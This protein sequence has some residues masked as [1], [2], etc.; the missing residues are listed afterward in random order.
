MRSAGPMIV[1]ILVRHT[2]RTPTLGEGEPRDPDLHR[3]SVRISSSKSSTSLQH[4]PSHRH[5]GTRK[6]RWRA[7]THPPPS[8]RQVRHIDCWS[9][10]REVAGN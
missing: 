2:S 4:S 9:Y 8:I 1:A 3:K 7:A 6:R 10:W 5:W